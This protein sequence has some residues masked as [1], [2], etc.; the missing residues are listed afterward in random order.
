MG[1]NFPWH[2]QKDTQPYLV[3]ITLL[4]QACCN[5]MTADNLSYYNCCADC[6]GF[7]SS[8]ILN[9]CDDGAGFVIMGCRRLRIVQVF[10]LFVFVCFLFHNN[11]NKNCTELWAVLNP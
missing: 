1:K 10:V 2:C 3:N 9:Y 5:V 11:N 7:M 8:N 6:F 4:L